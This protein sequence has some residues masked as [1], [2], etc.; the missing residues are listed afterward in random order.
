MNTFS[1]EDRQAILAQSRALLREDRR[2]DRQVVDNPPAEL[3]LLTNA[4]I[5]DLTRQHR[6]ASERE[7]PRERR[8][9]LD[10]RMLTVADVNTLIDAK[11]AEVEGRI[12]ER[13]NKLLPIIDAIFSEAL[14]AD[15]KHHV[16]A[17]H[18]QQ[19]Q[20]A[21]LDGAVRVLEMM[22]GGKHGEIV[23]LKRVK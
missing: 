21:K 4:Q 7:P 22:L 8:R 15:H 11:L 3:P 1:D 14:N 23:D 5:D 12:N 17:Q 6:E 9:G 19:L 18:E 2:E 10:Q 16:D 13:I 20:F